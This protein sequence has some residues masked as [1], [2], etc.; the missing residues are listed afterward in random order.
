MEE[1]MND[2]PA[3]PSSGHLD[4]TGSTV[5]RDENGHIAHVFLDQITDAID[6]GDVSA[7][8]A[9]AGE[10]HEADLGD[11]IGGMAA[12]C[13]PRLIELLGADFNFAALT[14]L[15]ETVRVEL[16][17]QLPTHVIV[18]GMRNLDSDDAIYI[19]EDLDD[20]HRAEIL[21]LLPSPERVALTRGLDFPDDSA[22]R[23][24]QTNF[25]AIPP[26]WTVGQTVDFLR[27]SDDLPNEFYEINVIDPGY[28]LIGTV[29]LDKLM[30]SRRTVRMDAILRDD[31]RIVGAGQDQEDVARMFERYNLVSAPVVDEYERLVGVLTIDDIVDVIQEEADED[32]RA[33]GGVVGDEEI[34]DKFLYTARSR[35]PWLVVNLFTAFISA[36]VINFFNGSIEKMVALAILMPIVASMGGN[37]GTQA[38][39]VTVRALAA[40][41]LGGRSARRVILREVLVGLSNGLILALIL[42]AVA[43]LWFM[44]LQ[45]GAVIGLALVVNMFTAGLSGA[46][47][48]LL[49]NRLKIDPAVASGVFLTTM[50]DVIGFFVFLGLASWWFGLL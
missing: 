49:L 34:S 43:A 17:K 12:E 48:P 5:P 23:R 11:L 10:L 6:A 30:R 18:E 31:R 36:S 22:G 16:I 44:N 2:I 3:F 26:F 14:E 20:D 47:I 7:L 4:A 37:A 13:R 25:I 24:M 29:A 41:E 39:T 19:L 42:G 33:L 32:I 8:Q 46:S 45:L 15:D 9:M 35:L 21:Q 1:S 27:V 40:R 50:T 28:K 38:M